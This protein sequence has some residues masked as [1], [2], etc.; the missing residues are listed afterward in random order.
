MVELDSSVDRHHLG[1][2]RHHPHTELDTIGDFNR[3][4]LF[5]SIR[6]AIQSPPPPAFERTNFELQPCYFDLVSREK[7]RGTDNTAF[8]PVLAIFFLCFREHLVPF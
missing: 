7:F 6:S 4:D 1:V 3:A 8:K 5:Y 2:D